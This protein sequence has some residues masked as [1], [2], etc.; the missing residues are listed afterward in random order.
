MSNGSKG[1]CGGAW[2]PCVL[3]RG[4]VN[5]ILRPNREPPGPGLLSFTSMVAMGV[6][7]LGPSERVAWCK[8]ASLAG[9]S[10]LVLP[11]SVRGSGKDLPLGLGRPKCQM[12]VWNVAFMSLSRLYH[13]P[14]L[15]FFI[16][17]GDSSHCS[18]VGFHR[19]G[20][21]SGGP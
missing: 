8:G 4:S 14:N 17:N 15:S 13:I 10:Q 7:P 18:L 1:G 3:G 2:N 21:P 6:F 12:I 5:T 11:D 20:M 9:Q 19:M 16:G